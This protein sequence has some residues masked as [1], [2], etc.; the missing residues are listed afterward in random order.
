MSY[1]FLLYHLTM[2]K[3]LAAQAQYVALL[4]SVRVTLPSVA[5]DPRSPHL[6]LKAQKTGTAL[7]T[8]LVSKSV[9]TKHL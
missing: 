6:C 2:K 9:Y 4:V 8:C 1:Y 5:A 3:T 7:W